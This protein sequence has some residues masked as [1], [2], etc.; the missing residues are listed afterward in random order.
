[1]R[2]VGRASREVSARMTTRHV[3]HTLTT[4][5]D[6]FEL[7]TEGATVAFPFYHSRLRPKPGHRVIVRPARSR[8][9]FVECVVVAVEEGT[10]VLTQLVRDDSPFDCLCGGTFSVS[11][12]E[13]MVVHSQPMCD[14]FRDLAPD[15]FVAMINDRHE[16][17]AN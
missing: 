13:G 5:R 4:D 1:M 10:N 14:D 15:A 11:A 2:T 7:L 9:E 16:R 17:E 12:E 8:D 3:R 6:R